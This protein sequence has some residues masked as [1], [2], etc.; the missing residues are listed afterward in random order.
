M[1]GHD[2]G[3][4]VEDG[5]DV[6]SLEHVEERLVADAASDNQQLRSH[7]LPENKAMA[8]P[9]DMRVHGNCATPLSTCTAQP[10]K[11]LHVRIPLEAWKTAQI[12]AIQ[13]GVSFKDYLTHILLL[14]RPLDDVSAT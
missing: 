10:L 6:S 11:D 8:D 5:A 9:L 2:S 1:N 4:V 14:A 13:S 12:A 7:S 3:Q